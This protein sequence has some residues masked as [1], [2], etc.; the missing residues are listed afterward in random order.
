MSKYIFILLILWVHLSTYAQTGV[1]TRRIILD[2]CD[3]SLG[4]QAVILSTLQVNFRGKNI[5]NEFT[6]IDNQ[7]FI[8][9]EFCTSHRGDT[10][11]I[12]FRALPI[13]LNKKYFLIDS[14]ELKR[15]DTEI[16]IGYE[17][18]PYAANNSILSKGL[19]YSGSFSRGFSIGNSQSLVLNSNLNL[20]LSGDLGNGLKI[21]AAISD[22]NLPIQAEGNTQVLQEFDKVFIE[23][24]KDRTKVIAGDY[25]LSRPKSYF[26]NYYKKL[27]GLGAQSIFNPIKKTS[28]TTSANI[29]SS[30][31]KFARQILETKEGNQGPYRMKGNNNERYIIIL[32]GTEKVYLDGRLLRRGLDFDYIIDYNSADLSFSPHVLIRNESRIIVE[33]EYTDVS[34]FRTLYT[35][36]TDVQHEKY[37]LSFNFYSEQD[38]KN[39][40][41]QIELSEGDKLLL[42]NA[43]DLPAVRSGIIP[44]DTSISQI[45]YRLVDNPDPADPIRQFLQFEP[46]YQLAEIG[47]V[48]TEVGVG[49]GSYAIDVV[50]GA[51]GR[52]YKFVGSAKGSYEPINRLV[53]PELKQAMSLGGQFRINKALSVRSEIG[54]S[55]NDKNTF[56]TISDDNNSGLAFMVGVNHLLYFKKDSSLVLESSGELEQVNTNFSP[57]NPYR[58]AEFARDWNLP[59]LYDRTGNEQIA[60]VALLLKSKLDNVVGYRLNRYSQPGLLDGLRHSVLLRQNVYGVRINSNSSLTVTEDKYKRT[61]FWRPNLDLQKSLG[62]FGLGLYLENEKNSQRSLSSD[63]ILTSSFAYTL[64]KTYIQLDSSASTKLRLGFNVRNDMRSNGVLLKDAIRIKEVE[65]DGGMIN[66]ENHRL[67]LNVKYR[68]FE[69][70]DPA[71]ITTEKSKN[72]LLGSV[73]HSLSMLNRAVTFQTNY[74]I[75]SGQEPK[76]EYV[77]SEIKN[78]RGDYVY[79]GVDSGGVKN[80]NDFRYDPTNPLASYI[81]IA[82]PNNEF[83]LTN[84]ISLNEYVYID[85]KRIWELDT[86]P[87]NTLKKIL[88]KI[89]LSAA[90]KLNNKDANTGGKGYNLLSFST[91]DTSLISYLSLQNYGFFFNRGSSDYDVSIIQR[92]DKTKIN[93][94]NGIEDRSL[95][96]S[97]IRLRATMFKNSDLILTAANGDKSFSNKILTSRNFD[98]TYWRMQPQIEIRPNTKMRYS[99]AYK[100]ERR[101]QRILNREEANIQTFELVFNRRQASTSAIDV[102]FS[103]VS[104]D[105]T[106][107][108]NGSIEYDILDGLKNGSN[109]LWNASYTHRFSNNIDLNLNYEGRKTSTSPAVHVMR[110]QLKATF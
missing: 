5:T 20:Q 69:V 90:L 60:N 86:M 36:N 66:S 82:L 84:N 73:D 27:K 91:Q 35:I 52:V 25:E 99:L 12:F 104:I 22:E 79:I 49:K 103:F 98:I 89:S 71:L 24:S 30:R 63:S 67:H 16:Y 37:S 107:V 105:Y 62:L 43:G 2:G 56:S 109:L 21:V 48:F 34:Y 46:N 81:R 101:L 76:L 45:G 18:D 64:V 59:S 68:N 75:N 83:T 55:T 39:S 70:L 93:L 72:T 38:S 6:L 8:S 32:S 13:N 65:A 74:I 102:S 51:N 3:F 100:R 15:K 95:E 78:N 85:T 58:N 92:K 94:I 31:G 14:S 97:E 40:T 54:L 47:A 26:M 108:Q 11:E 10:L 77:F 4:N 96:E 80:Y 57:L 33:F 53:A 23:L 19:N 41:S 1:Q 17:F 42:A 7:L 28:V 50:S 106:G 44:L 88:S 61:Q 29:A 110:A 87:L 9:Q